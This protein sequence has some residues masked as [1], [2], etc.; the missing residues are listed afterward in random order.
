MR[1][2]PLAV[3][4]EIFSRGWWGLI[5][6]ALVA[7]VFPAILFTALQREGGYDTGDQFMV[8]MHLAL[9]QINMFIFSAAVFG[10][11]GEI[12]RLFGYPVQTSS[13][14]AWQMI[15]AMVLVHWKFWPALRRS[16]LCFMSTGLC[17]DRHC[18]WR[19]GS[20]PCKR[21]VG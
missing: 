18:S 6:T 5:G 12:S 2:M 19:S 16:M 1:S 20:P 13:L 7:N 10:A 9:V 14:V 8:I 11:Q 17:G 4:W 3:T 15:P 21:H